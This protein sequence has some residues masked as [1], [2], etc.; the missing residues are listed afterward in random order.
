[1]GLLEKLK[2]ALGLGGRSRRRRDPEITVE[3]RP[4]TESEDAVKGTDAGPRAPQSAS[5]AGADDQPSAD[6]SVEEPTADEET[7]PN[8]QEITGIG[9]TYAER[10]ADAGIE[11][12]ADLAEADA[13]SVAEAAET[14]QSRARDWIE[15]AR[16]R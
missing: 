5:A 7:A 6:E 12:I 4:S 8:I 13:S 9:P 15:Q 1:M 16:D 10:L 2:A 3:R 14:S 11:T